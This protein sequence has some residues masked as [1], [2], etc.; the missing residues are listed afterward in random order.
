MDEG[1]NHDDDDGAASSR[2]GALVGLIIILVLGILAV[3]LVRELGRQS[4]LQDCLMSGRD[5]LRARSRRRPAINRPP[6]TASR[7]AHA[8]SVVYHRW[9]IF[10]D[11]IARLA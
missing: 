10:N 11:M 3:V 8:V 4:N 9:C 5:Q 7:T 1:A 6:R 2:R